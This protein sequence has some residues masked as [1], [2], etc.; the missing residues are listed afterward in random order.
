MGVPDKSSRVPSCSKDNL[1]FLALSDLRDTEAGFL[2][3]ISA[4]SL[5]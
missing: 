3:A 2:I 5:M 1:R 4:F